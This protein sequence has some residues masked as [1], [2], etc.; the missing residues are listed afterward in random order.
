MSAVK[1]EYLF[2]FESISIFMLVCFDYLSKRERYV[3]TP[4]HAPV[5][6]PYTGMHSYAKKYFLPCFMCPAT[7]VRTDTATEN[8]RFGLLKEINYKY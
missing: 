1:M 4:A 3:T 5:S 6:F 7:M 2:C 8:M